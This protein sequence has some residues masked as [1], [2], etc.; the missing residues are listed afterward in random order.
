MQGFFLLLF[1]SHAKIVSL[2]QTN[3]H[4]EKFEFETQ[5]LNAYQDFGVLPPS[6]EGVDTTGVLT[7]LES[8]FLIMAS[9]VGVIFVL[10]IGAMALCLWVDKAGENDFHSC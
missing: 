6:C 4:M 2:K 8:A 3:K 10:S 9:V 1:P 5:C 7:N